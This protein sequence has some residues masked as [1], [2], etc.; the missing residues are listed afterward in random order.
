MSSANT[1]VQALND[2]IKATQTQTSTDA[3][4][5]Q[6]VKVA[7]E[8]KNLGVVCAF[9]DGHLVKTIST[10][11]ENKKQAPLRETAYLILA[12]VSKAVGQ[13]AEPYLI[14]LMPRVLDGYADKVAPVREAA[15]EAS[16]AIMALPSRY[17]V[18]LLLPVLFDSIENGRWQSQCGSLQLLAGL[19]KS[20]PKVKHGRPPWLGG[21]FPSWAALWF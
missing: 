12:A 7:D 2:F 11:L 8:V 4:K 19:S 6:A 18:K 20:S 13:A 17:A 16:K 3:R 9:R 21:Y 1:N 10:L 5:S 15:D 14:P